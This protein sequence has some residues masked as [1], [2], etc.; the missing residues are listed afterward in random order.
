M[1]Q[2]SISAQ[3]SNLQQLVADL[4]AIEN[5]GKKALEAGVFKKALT[6][7]GQKISVKLFCP[8]SLNTLFTICNSSVRSVYL[9]FAAVIFSFPSKLMV[10]F[11]RLHTGLSGIQTSA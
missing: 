7:I 4:E 9:Y 8:F 3:L 5:G 6:Q 10:R 2:N 11:T 1:P